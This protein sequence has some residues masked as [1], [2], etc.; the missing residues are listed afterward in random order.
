[1]AQENQENQ[2][3]TQNLT[4]HK[5]TNV[6]IGAILLIVILITAGIVV[7]YFVRQ[8]KQ[9]REAAE[10]TQIESEEEA[11]EEET[12]VELEEDQYTDFSLERF[13]F[14]NEEGGMLS[15]LSN[16]QDIINLSEKLGTNRI[17]TNFSGSYILYTIVSDAKFEIYSAD[18][19]GLLK[20]QITSISR[21]G[22]DDISLQLISDSGQL[23][24]F[25]Y[26]HSLEREIGPLCEPEFEP[27]I[28]NGNYYYYFDSGI[29]K[30]ES[31]TSNVEQL[32]PLATDESDNLFLIGYDLNREQNLVYK[33]ETN[34]KEPKLYFRFPKEISR[35]SLE[36]SQVFL[37]TVEKKVWFRYGIPSHLSNVP[38][39]VSKIVVY[40]YGN[41]SYKEITPTGSWA[42]FQRLHVSPSFEYIIYG[43]YGPETTATKVRDG[44][45]PSFEYYV[46]NAKTG[47]TSLLPF[48]GRGSLQLVWTKA[49]KFIYRSPLVESWPVRLLGEVIEFNLNN[50]LTKVIIKDVREL[51]LPRGTYFVR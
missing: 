44:F 32:Q 26:F 14:S 48:G 9:E 27:E 46:Y 36:I 6:L 20:K 41:E 50:W 47:N 13:I 31:L 15:A 25:S 19:K 1:M 29:R 33:L 16:G 28:D 43:R 23:V 40:D 4:P 37:D 7:W 45:I 34:N 22:C 39:G 49:D 3:E 10:E 2:F 12:V 35:R 18:S 17:I 38:Y 5:R 42:E 11:T 24:L 30:M 21:T 8:E 51:L